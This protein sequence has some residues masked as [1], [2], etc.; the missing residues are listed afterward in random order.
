VPDGGQIFEPHSTIHRFGMLFAAVNRDLVTACG[1]SRRK[2]LGKSLK[3]AV[4]RGDAPSAEDREPHSG[5][6]FSRGL[7]DCGPGRERT[8]GARAGSQADR[9]TS[10]KYSRPWP[11]GA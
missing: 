8:D 6:L 4:A 10:W 1:E 11:C 5:A 3:A 9:R 2:L 7:R